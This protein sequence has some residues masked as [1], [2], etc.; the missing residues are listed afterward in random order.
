MALAM[1]NTRVCDKLQDLSG[2]DNFD[3]SL[4]DAGITVWEG[5]SPPNRYPVR[6][7]ATVWWPGRPSHRAA[8]P[9][10]FHYSLRIWISEGCSVEDR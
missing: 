9:N 10:F 6:Y 1:M 7:S 2:P 3:H 4:H 8:S 5:D